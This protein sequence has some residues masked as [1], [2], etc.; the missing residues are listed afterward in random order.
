[1]RV[2]EQLTTDQNAFTE[3]TRRLDREDS[4]RVRLMHQRQRF[5]SK[6]MAHLLLPDAFA[7]VAAS[8]PYNLE[9]AV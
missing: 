4:R 1:M 3:R 7:H 5:V 9:F 6:P 8:F 2:A